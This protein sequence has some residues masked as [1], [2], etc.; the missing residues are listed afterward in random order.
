[1]ELIC[2][3]EI[4]EKR[5]KKYGVIAPHLHLYMFAKAGHTQKI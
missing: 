4:Q 5:Y 1:M 3:T 2:C